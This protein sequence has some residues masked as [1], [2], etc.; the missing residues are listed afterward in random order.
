MHKLIMNPESGYTV[1]HKN[2]LRY[3]NRKSNL[4]ICTQA[5][6]NMNQRLRSCN[7]TGCIGVYYDRGKYQAK[8][9]INNETINLGRYDNFEDAVKARKEAEKKYFGEYAYDTSIGAE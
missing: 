7:T 1:D 4:R 9:F 3:D 2:H 5:Q 8:I 6:N